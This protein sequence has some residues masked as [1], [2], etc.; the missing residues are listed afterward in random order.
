MHTYPR[1]GAV[2]V[3][4]LDASAG[5]NEEQAMNG[6]F[7]SPVESSAIAAA[8]RWRVRIGLLAVAGVVVL[9]PEARGQV[10]A[11]PDREVLEVLY[12]ATGG[13]NWLDNTNWL[14][15]APLSEW[16]GVSTNLLGRVVNLD[17]RDNDLVGPIPLELAR[18]THL[19]ELDLRQ[20]Q[21]SGPIPPELGTLP[22]LWFLSLL[23]N[24]LS[25]PIPPE[26]GQLS[27][28]Q[29]LHLD[30]NRL[31][32]PIPPE[33]LQLTNL[34]YLGLAVN[35]LSGPI[36]PELGQLT[37]LEML[38]LGQN[39]LTGPIPPEL[40]QLTALRVH[41][42]L[43]GNPLGGTIPPELGRL[44]NLE[45]LSLQSSRLSGAIPPELGRLTRL[46]WLSLFNNRLS[47]PIPVELGDLTELKDLLLDGDTGL[48]L[49]PEI[50]DTLFGRLT[51]NNAVPLCAAV[52]TLPRA[53][54]WVLALA[55]VLLGVRRNGLRRQAAA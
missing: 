33:L 5:E 39:R 14:S 32:G 27:N 4:T 13:P 37:R 24:Q 40:G 30:L 11:D 9:G 36:P 38:Q 46:E 16:H 20:N 53:G 7:V 28:L 15:D 22:N 17:L 21:L 2:L 51:L 6:R 41:L 3:A 45:R 10:G 29:N 8:S 54:L 31:S 42:D 49:P 35:D 18:L 44:T 52:T 34:E 43:A 47:G 26:L 1:Q 12:H 48:C 25:G 50:Q 23:N 19:R 55:L